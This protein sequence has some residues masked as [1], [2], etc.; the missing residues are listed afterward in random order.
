MTP[1]QKLQTVLGHDE[2]VDVRHTLL[3]VNSE[4][5]DALTAELNGKS[6]QKEPPQY[7]GVPYPVVPFGEVILII[8]VPHGAVEI[9]RKIA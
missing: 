3:E 4:F 7:L 1:S 6:I 8:W 5:Y 9:R 2:T